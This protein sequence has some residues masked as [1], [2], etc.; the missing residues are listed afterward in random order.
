MMKTGLVAASVL[1][2]LVA[3]CSPKLEQGEVLEK[4]GDTFTIRLSK[5]IDEPIVADKS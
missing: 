4:K 2:V 3:G 1:A 5:T